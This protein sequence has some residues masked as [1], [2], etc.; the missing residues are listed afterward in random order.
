MNKQPY[1][2]RF[3]EAWRSLQVYLADLDP[4]ELEAMERED[5]DGTLALLAQQP[6]IGSAVAHASA[7]ARTPEE[8]AIAIVKARLDALAL[9]ADP[10]R[11]APWGARFVQAWRSTGFPLSAFGYGLIQSLKGADRDG[12]IDLLRAHL[13][14]LPGTKLDPWQATDPAALAASLGQAWHLRQLTIA[15]LW[16]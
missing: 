1:G 9:S 11:R 14:I 10:A 6:A 5:F 2:A 15:L 4:A 3:A 8:L 16:M 12:A 7:G 13:K